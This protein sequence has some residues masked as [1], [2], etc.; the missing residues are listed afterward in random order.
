[1]PFFSRVFKGKEATAKKRVAPAPKLNK[2][3]QWSDAW[4]RTRVDPEEVVELLREC[5][6]E[7]KSR[8]ENTSHVSGRQQLTLTT[9]ALDI[10]FLLLPFRPSSD[11]SA[12]RTFVRNYF[13]PQTDREALRGT[14]LTNEVKMTDVMVWKEF[15]TYAHR[16]TG[17]PD[18]CQCHEVVL[19]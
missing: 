16:L 18:P 12:A 13:L 7:L 4:V 6:N 15:C 1:M 11:P 10:P 9:T 3:P 2:K 17:S 14:A 5:T 8:G 19:E